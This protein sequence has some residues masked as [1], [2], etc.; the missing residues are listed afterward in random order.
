MRKFFQGHSP[1]G[2]AL[3]FSVFAL[4]VFLRLFDLSTQSPWTDEIATWWYVKNLDQVFLRESHTPL[5]YGILRVFF[6][7]DPTI[8]GIRLF[9]ASLSILH[10]IEFFFLGQL[11]LGKRAFLVFWVLVC[12]SPADIVFARM[13]RHYA[14]L[15]EGTLVYYLLWRTGVSKKLQVLTAAFMGGLHLF[16]MIP[17]LVLGG[18]DFFRGKK[19]EALIG[20]VPVGI[21]GTY[22]LVRTIS[23]GSEKVLGNV[24]WVRTESFTYLSS[25]VTQF[26]GDAYPRFEYYP[27]TPE[28]AGVFFA[29]SLGVLFYFKRPSSLHFLL[30]FAASVVFVEFLS[31][32]VNL[33]VNRYLIYLPGLLSFALAESLGELRDRFLY[34][35]LVLPLL[36]IV[37]FNPFKN[38]PWERERVEAFQTALSRENFEQVLVCANDYQTDYFKLPRPRPCHEEA[39]SLVPQKSL[40]FFD[41]LGAQKFVMARFLGEMNVTSVENFDHGSVLVQFVPKSPERKNER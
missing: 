6:G 28:I 35:V 26:L 7:D 36:W 34:P 3:L 5:F 17:A 41:L 30:I 1:V 10:L 8:F 4:A 27:V 39:L 13:A 18:I 33:R 12:L 22:Y 15:L 37:L 21:M 16:F 2:V 24:S 32:W 20:L 19:K 9:V 38:F 31:P 40:L 11:A 23:F 29:L 14:W 25:L